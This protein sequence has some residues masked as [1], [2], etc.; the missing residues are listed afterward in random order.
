[1][2][3]GKKNLRA[4]LQIA[5]LNIRGGGSTQTEG[6][7]QHVNQIMRDRR[8][9]I[10]AVQETH[11]TD[12][13][14][15]SL[16]E[17]F[18]KRILIHHTSDTEHPNSKGVALVFN[19]DETACEEA[20]SHVI[21]PGRA[22]YTQLPW[23]GENKFHI[24]AIYAPNNHTE[25]ADFW[26]EI[27][28]ILREEHLPHPDIVLGDF[29]LVEDQLDR[30]PSH[31]D[32][33]RATSALQELKSEYNLIDGWR[34]ENENIVQYTYMQVGG[35]IHSRLDR[36]YINEA[37]LPNTHKWE[38]QSIGIA[39]DHKLVS[40]QVIN[41]TKPWIGKGRW[42]V[43][44]SILKDK[45]ALDEL[46]ELGRKIVESLPA[47]R[48]EEN[49]AQQKLLEFKNQARVFLRTWAREAG[50]RRNAQISKMEKDLQ[51]TINDLTQPLEERQEQATVLELRLKEIQKSQHDALR[52]HVA[53]R[54]RLEGETNST[55]WTGLN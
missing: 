44:L 1:R 17:Q 28:Q 38:I 55:Y 2:N 29:N 45:K 5:T 8:I 46:R 20:T 48:T 10:L 4:T 13:I 3:T 26:E 11:L 31:P 52:I 42:S 9:G 22:L 39:T 15:D 14:V 24:L 41:P 43:P 27:T 25:N 51:I 33:E 23:K 47:L 34:Y 30:M 12:T 21:I 54:N 50:A 49:N 40:A 16:H 37:L 18:G 36:I 19:R 53:A 32:P 7:W 6:K 35:K